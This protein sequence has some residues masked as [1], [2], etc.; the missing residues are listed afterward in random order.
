M[1]VEKVCILLS[2]IKITTSEHIVKERLEKRRVSLLLGLT[3]VI[4]ALV[5]GGIQHLHLYDFYGS[6]LLNQLCFY[7][8]VLVIG[9]VGTVVMIL[10]VL[11]TKKIAY[12]I[13]I[14]LI[15]LVSLVCTTYIYNNSWILPELAPS[16]TPSLSLPVAGGFSIIHITDTQ[17]LSQSNPELFDALT[18]WIV[19]N[20]QALNLKMVIHTGDIV[21]IAD[22]T[23]QFV[24]ANNAMIQLYNNG[25]PYCWDAGNHDQLNSTNEAGD[26]N[27]NGSWIGGNYPAFN[28]SIM[29]QEPYWVSN[30]GSENTATQFSYGNYRFMVINLEYDANQTVLAWMENLLTANPTVNVII[31]THSFLNGAGGYGFT[32]NPVDVTWATNFEK[33]IQKY[34]NIFMT[35]NG[36]CVNVGDNVCNKKV[37]NIEEIYFNYQGTGDVAGS[38]NDTGASNAQILVFNMNNP[39]HLTVSVY[40]YEVTNGKYITNLAN[41]Y[42]FAVKLIS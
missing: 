28:I 33:L 19:N 18:S 10:S 8:G 27:P 42:S 21:N 26:G 24:N 16:N 6:G 2:N 15:F 5:L 4:V 31:A 20:S 32:C 41:Q 40:V 34:P 11:K 29:S 36:H 9:V 37:G 17:F 7:G 14:I 3:F 1:I 23:A 30:F 13:I 39:E 25:I 38:S 12:S 35:L 22:S